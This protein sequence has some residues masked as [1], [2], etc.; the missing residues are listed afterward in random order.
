MMHD[1]G[2]IQVLFPQVQALANRI[3]SE[4]TEVEHARG[5]ERDED[6]FRPINS[7]SSSTPRAPHMSTHFQ[8]GPSLTPEALDFIHRKTATIQ[9]NILQM[10]RDVNKLERLA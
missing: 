5:G 8:T 6:G 1:D 3:H 4:V 2:S 7:S 9:S 10:E